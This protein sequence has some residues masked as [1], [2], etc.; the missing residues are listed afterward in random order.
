MKDTQISKKNELK[1]NKWVNT[2]SSIILFNMDHINNALSERLISKVD[3]IIGADTLKKSKALI[4][5]E[6]KK[7]YL[8]L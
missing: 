2:S 8:K 1:I 7:L 4:D 5:Y 6:K 3:G